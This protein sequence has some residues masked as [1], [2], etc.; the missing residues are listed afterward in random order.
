MADTGIFA[1]TAQIGYKAG[2]RKSATSA[3]E[4]YTNFFIG[5]AESYIN[6]AAGYNFSDNYSSLNVDV[7]YILQEAASNLAAIYVINYDMSGT[8]M[9]A[10]QRIDAESMVTILYKRFQDCIDLLKT[11]DKTKFINGA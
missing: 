11:S 3:T 8:A 6:V 5:Q 9:T 10:L 7:K 4:A 2:V 1:T